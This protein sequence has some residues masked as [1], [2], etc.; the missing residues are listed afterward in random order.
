MAD[1]T[2]LILKTLEYFRQ[3]ELIKSDDISLIGMQNLKP[4]AI[5]NSTKNYAWYVMT[6]NN[7]EIRLY[8]IDPVT[9]EYQGDFISIQ[10]NTITKAKTK[11]TSV[12]FGNQYFEIKYS[13][14]DIFIGTLDKVYNHNQI[15]DIQKM[16]EFFEN[17]F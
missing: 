6:A 4:N 10:L 5:F 17:H 7:T 14:R 3:R 1:Q 8:N 15:N 16:V 12:F 11:R 9:H 2:Y 13:N